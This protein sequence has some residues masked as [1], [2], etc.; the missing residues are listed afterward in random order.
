M[1]RPPLSIVF[2]M[3]GMKWRARFANGTVEISAPG[4]CI[5]NLRLH[6][7]QRTG[8]QVTIGPLTVHDPNGTL[9]RLTEWAA[10]FARFQ[11]EFHPANAQTLASIRQQLEQQP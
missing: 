1:I 2:R 4:Y 9:T 6:H 8:D 5:R 7:L 11:G 3:A 10:A